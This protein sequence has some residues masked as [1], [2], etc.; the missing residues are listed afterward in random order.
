[1]MD[2][3]EKPVA[4][5]GSDVERRTGLLL[6]N[7]D[8]W[9]RDRETTDRTLDCVRGG[10]VS[11]VSA[12]VFM[13][14]SDRAAAMSREHQ[15]DAGLH[16]NL[17]TPFTAGHCSAR[18]RESQ[19]KTVRYLLRYRLAQVLFHPG[20]TNEFEYVVKSQLDEFS[21]LYGTAP[22]RIDGHHH[23]HL[24]ANVLSQGLLPQGT[25]IRRNF[26]FEAGEKSVWNRLYRRWV[27]GRLAKQHRLTDYFYSLTPLEPRSRVETI[28]L[29]SR[30]NV[31]EVEVHPVNKD[32]YQFLMEG[33]IGRLG[34]DVKVGFVV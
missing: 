12:M 21:R 34:G 15:I 8:D 19:E 2:D 7:A 20:L 32:E 17:T 1:M 18:L 26:S 31:V 4:M 30:D 3:G 5:A 27:D 24:C 9:G 25:I 22:S 33:G 6:I 11:S 28:F 23:M 13:N 29:R 16:L 14:D 10:S